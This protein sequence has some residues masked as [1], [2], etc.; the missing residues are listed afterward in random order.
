M[1]NAVVTGG[2]GFIGSHIAENY[3]NCEEIE[4]IFVIDNLSRGKLLNKEVKNLN[5]NWNFLEKFNKINLIKHDIRDFEFLK[6]FF[7]DNEIDIIFHTA[8]QTAV[9][10]SII[11]PIPDFENNII[12]T[13]NLLESV[14]LSKTDP[15]LVFCSTNKVFGNNVNQCDIIEEETRYS[16]KK[17]YINGI[18]EDFSID[19]CEHTP[20]GASKLCSD[21]YFQEYGHLYGLK[22]AVFR[23]SCIYGTRQLGFEDQGWV[24][25]FIISALTGKKINIF[26]DG[27][28][29]R[30]ILYVSDLIE[31]YDSY[32][33]NAD[34]IKHDVYCIG[35]G[36]DNTLSLIELINILEKELDKKVDHEFFEWRP[37]D[38]KVY[39]SDIGKA[40]KKLRWTPKVHPKQGVKR[41]I[42][43]VRNNKNLFI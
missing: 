24:A 36:A 13:F 9:T 31:A 2:A 39:I 22:T 33:Q 34:Q 30:D 21:I 12:G 17:Q 4:N 19:L 6:K 40:K 37:S 8:S 41:V 7:K 43:W 35:G 3:A 14:R 25:H 1:T 38:Q 29:L 16:F 23:M 11:E 32:I 5:Y 20:Y 42:E 27:K 18:S 26:G 10:T 28:Q 15:A